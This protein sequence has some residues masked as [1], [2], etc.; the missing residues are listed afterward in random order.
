M[1]FESIATMCDDID[2][3]GMNRYQDVINYVN[4][5]KLLCK[6]MVELYHI[7]RTPQITD[8]NTVNLLPDFDNDAHQAYRN[9]LDEDEIEVVSEFYDWVLANPSKLNHFD[10]LNEYLVLREEQFVFRIRG[11]IEDAMSSEHVFEQMFSNIEC[12]AN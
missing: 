6:F 8:I 9:K 3:C 10:L 12:V 4:S 7:G 2:A 5:R 1:D 11:N